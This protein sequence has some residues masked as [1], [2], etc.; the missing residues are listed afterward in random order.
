MS[1]LK[2]KEYKQFED[3][4]RIREDGTEFW[5][6]RELAPAL[7]Y[8][9][10]ENFNKVIKRAMIACENAGRSVFHHFPAVRKTVTGGVA[11]RKMI[12]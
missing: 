10:W 12:D 7:G 8:T 2:G 6:A 11:P 5:T 9:K 1:E 3:I 4:K